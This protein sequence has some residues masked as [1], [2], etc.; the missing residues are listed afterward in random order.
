ME[1]LGLDDIEAGIVLTIK[2][3]LIGEPLEEI[4]VA[5][6]VG[7]PDAVREV[8]VLKGNVSVTT[9]LAD[10]GNVADGEPIVDENGR[11]AYIVVD[12]PDLEV[13]IGNTMGKAVEAPSVTIPEYVRVDIGVTIVFDSFDELEPGNIEVD[14]EFEPESLNDSEDE[15]DI[16][17]E[18]ASIDAVSYAMGDVPADATIGIT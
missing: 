17:R 16:V 2:A 1:V 15:G 14:A 18:S 8:G 3:V 10:K 7:I 6:V 5:N 4:I 12:M 13:P 9:E 11:S